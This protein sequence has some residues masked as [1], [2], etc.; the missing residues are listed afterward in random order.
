MVP[1][2][3]PHNR[4][5]RYGAP[6][7]LI[8]VATLFAAADTNR[9]GNDVQTAGTAVGLVWF[10]VAVGRDMGMGV[11]TGRRPRVPDPPPDD[12]SAADGRQPPVSPS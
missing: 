8:I 1:R 9:L 7:A 10:M 3:R 4:W 6:I 11:A 5:I 12:D 2:E